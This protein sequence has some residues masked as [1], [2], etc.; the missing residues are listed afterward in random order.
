MDPE[1]PA[2]RLVNRK[3]RVFFVASETGRKSGIDAPRVV[4]SM[5]RH[6]GVA[7]SPRPV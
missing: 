5:E 4:Q 3:L 2:H 6:F 1:F 7:I